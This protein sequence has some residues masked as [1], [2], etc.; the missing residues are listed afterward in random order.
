MI[1]PTA[2][3]SPKAELDSEVEVGPYSIIGDNVKISNQTRIG[4]HVVIDGWTSI[5]QNCQIFPFASIGAIPQDLKFKGEESQLIIGNGNV[6]REFVTINRATALGIGK[7]ILGNDNFLMVY[8]HVAHDCKIGNQVIIA[9]AVALAGHIEVEDFAIIGGLVGVHQF[10]KIGCYSI[11][12]ACSAVSQDVPPYTMAV[13]NHAKLH[14]LNTVGLK[15]HHFSDEAIRNLKKAY[16]IIFRSGLLLK[17]ALE[18]VESEIPGS[19]EV[20]NLI[21]FIRRS[22][23]GIIR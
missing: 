10:V 3:V 6:I 21:T 17:K 16:Q 2:V 9:N 4:S 15:R 20:M 7:T 19:P 14:G 11:I 8:S 18:K 13:G 1:H 5:G 12:G 22:E 23:R